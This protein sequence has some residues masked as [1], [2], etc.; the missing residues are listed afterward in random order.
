MRALAVTK[1]NS[2]TL[3]FT[4]VVSMMISFCTQG[5]WTEDTPEHSND[6]KTE[7]AIPYK[8][9]YDRMDTVIK[10][11]VPPSIDENQLR[12][13]LAK[14]AND[15]QDDDA[16]DYIMLCCL[17]VEAYLIQGDKQSGVPAGTLKRLVPGLNPAERRKI[18]TDRTRDDTVTLTFTEARNSL[19]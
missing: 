5:C 17:W 13:T 16:R 14:A 11:G 8:I 9:I 15:H 1:T 6:L 2:K 7:K 12:A 10:I 19:R 4:V 18:T 3:R